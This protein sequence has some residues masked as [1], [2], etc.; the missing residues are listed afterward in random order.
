MTS[1]EP[2]KRPRRRRRYVAIPLAVLVG[3]AAVAALWPSPIDARAWRPGPPPPLAGPFA[4]NR[5]LAQGRL[6]FPESLRNPEH[7]AVDDRG[8]VYTGTVDGVVHRIV[9]PT[10][11]S[12]RLEAFATV[13]GRPLGMAFRPDGDLVVAADG[14]GLLAISP[15]G[16]V[17]RL[18]DRR[19]N[20]VAVAADGAVYFS[21]ATSLADRNFP[22]GMLEQRPYGSLLVLRPG[23][24]EPVILVDGLVFANG[25]ALTP[26]DEAVLVVESFRY[27]IHRHWL[28]GPR[29]GETEPWVEDLPAIPDNLATDDRGRVWVGFN[30]PR[31][32]LL[33]V[34]LHPR[35]WLKDQAAKAA[36]LIRAAGGGARYG[37]VA[38]FDSSGV[39]VRSLHDPDG[40]YR[41]TSAAV[42]DTEA[43]LLW[44]GSLFDDGLL[45]VPLPR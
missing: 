7:V 11:D 42:P 36:P 32:A 14:G 5:D 9:D 29:A 34:T 2:A 13:P 17:R 1:A 35:P 18:S 8:R 23:S 4:A 10:G 41:G 22:L 6:L 20:S 33:D 44:V 15:D 27:R 24:E 30:A 39:P 45:A 21:E 19:A 12:P 31:S 37:L 16:E 43:G 25:V 3:G 28:T 38:A 40:G 26:G